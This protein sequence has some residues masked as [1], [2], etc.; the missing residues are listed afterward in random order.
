MHKMG[1][2]ICCAKAVFESITTWVSPHPLAGE[3]R[4][5]GKPA[6]DAV[7]LTLLLMDGSTVTMTVCEDCETSNLP[8]AVM[9]SRAMVRT[10]WENENRACMGVGGLNDRQKAI[11]DETMMKLVFNPPLGV[12]GRSKWEDILTGSEI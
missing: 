9:W 3:M 5:V 12:L 11:V 2:C 4:K 8:L 1:C 6:A 7:R 10:Q